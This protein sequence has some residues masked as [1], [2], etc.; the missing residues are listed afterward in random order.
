MLLWLTTSAMAAE[1]RSDDFRSYL[2]QARFFIKRE[3]YED[4]VEQLE[5]AVQTDDGRRDA[6]AWFLL[7]KVRYELCDLV[8]ARQAAEQARLNSDDPQQFSQTHDLLAFYRESFGLVELTG[9]R[10]GLETEL[11][12]VLESTL[13]D[14]D[15]KNYFNKLSERLSGVSVAL[16]HTLGLPAGSYTINGVFVNVEAGEVLSLE[17]TL[18]GSGSNKLQSTELELGLGGSRW[19][20]ETSQSLAPTTE[21]S[22]GIP[23]GPMTLGILATWA[24]QP[25]QDRS[26]V[27]VFAPLGL[28]GGIR[29]GFEVQG[30]QPFVLRPSLVG[31][32][33]AV[34]GL[35]LTC[36]GGEVWSCARDAEPNPRYVYA[37]AM[38]VTGGLELAMLYQ[39]R[40]R[41]SGLGG[42]LKLAADLA[43]GQLPGAGQAMLPDRNVQFIVGEQGWAG[44][45][46]RAL[47]VLSYRF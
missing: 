29:V 42:G 32:F 45:S 27:N 37:T 36:Q 34:P 19:L 22:L 5:M 31:R 2:D 18:Y 15:L 6:E 43:A 23:A 16:P 11:S 20:G 1:T 30:L 3:W 28:T 44:T 17:P 33:G 26:G 10:P 14:P 35:E 9:S 46:V 13:F 8:G 7:A 40:S 24:P 21:V 38:V 39:D 25:F 4:A 41:N 12:L 47:G